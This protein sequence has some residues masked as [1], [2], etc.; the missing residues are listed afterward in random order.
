MGSVGP[1]LVVNRSA[2]GEMQAGQCQHKQM[3]ASPPHHETWASHELQNVDVS[4]MSLAISSHSE[5]QCAH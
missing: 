2:V 1:A 5:I 4:T 3:N